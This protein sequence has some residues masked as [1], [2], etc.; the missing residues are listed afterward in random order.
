VVFAL[1]LPFEFPCKEQARKQD[2]TGNAQQDPCH[3]AI[4]GLGFGW[5]AHLCHVPSI[6]SIG[7]IAGG[8]IVALPT[9]LLLQSLFDICAV[10]D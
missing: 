6:G 5:I 3:S 9:R 10:F 1:F 4:G 2:S 7:H 8:E